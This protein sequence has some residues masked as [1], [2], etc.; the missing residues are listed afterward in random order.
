M[1]QLHPIDLRRNARRIA[2]T[3][4]M[5]GKFLGIEDRRLAEQIAAALQGIESF[6]A[7]PREIL[8]AMADRAVRES[9]CQDLATHQAELPSEKAEISELHWLQM[10]G[11]RP[12]DRN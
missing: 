11:D 7:V 5:F 1:S 12:A 8:A 2:Y 9:R 4:A 6:E 3:W 10:P